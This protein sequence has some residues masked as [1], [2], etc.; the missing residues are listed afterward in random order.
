[1]ATGARE[2]SRRSERIEELVTRIESSGDPALRAVASE[3]L[4]AVVELHGIALE[5]ILDAVIEL[6]GGQETVDRLA[7]EE[8]VSGVLSLHGIHPEPLETRV[9]AALDE[10]RPYLKTHGGDVELAGISDGTVHLRLHGACGHCSSSAQT[11][12]STVE[13][14]IFRVAP[15][16]VAVITDEVPAAAHSDLVTLQVN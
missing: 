1:M 13:D 10:A 9:A 4:Q 6:P 8:L 7:A 5:R 2:F 14:A 11:M 3:L 16:V 12:K 15:E